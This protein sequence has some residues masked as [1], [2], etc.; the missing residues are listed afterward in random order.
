[1]SASISVTCGRFSLGWDDLCTACQ[2]VHEFQLD[3]GSRGHELLHTSVLIMKD[4]RDGNSPRCEKVPTGARAPRLLL[5]EDS[6]G[7]EGSLKYAE[8]YDGG[9]SRP[10][11][12]INLL[13]LRWAQA[14][15]PRDKVYALLSI[16]SSVSQTIRPDYTM[17]VSQVYTKTAT[18]LWFIPGVSKLSFL[19][20][21][22]HSDRKL[23]SHDLPSWVPDWRKELH[24]PWLINNSG[25]RTATAMAPKANQPNYL[26]PS[27]Q[28]NGATI[29]KISVVGPQAGAK[30]GMPPQSILNTLPNPYSS[31]WNET[32]AEALN[33]SEDPLGKL[34]PSMKCACRAPFWTWHDR[35][36]DRV[37]TDSPQ[38]H[39]DWEVLAPPGTATPATIGSDTVEWDQLDGNVG[40]AYGRRVF[41]T[42]L[43]YIGLV[44]LASMVGDEVCVLLGSKVP[45]VIRREGTQYRFV[46]ECYVF[47]MMD[48]EVLEGI[49]NKDVGFLEFI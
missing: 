33:F 41:I 8:I 42:D 32:L 22:Q 12:D 17:S 31:E 35:V 4:T 21:V 20:F 36:K 46:G 18:S 49:D 30:A 39:G 16:S 1:M 10:R 7:P 19:S 9:S 45:Y 15:D 40:I 44:P 43:G 37:A 29:M 11:F 28:I 6:E 14:T 38:D 47:G 25:F 26:S 27:I 34:A 48:G 13:L 3:V 24:A 23:L 2:F 5:Q